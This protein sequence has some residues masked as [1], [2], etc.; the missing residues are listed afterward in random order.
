M[1]TSSVIGHCHY[2]CI[3]LKQIYLFDL[4]RLDTGLDYKTFFLPNSSYRQNNW[5]SFSS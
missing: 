3:K 4:K 2:S 5:H 1:I